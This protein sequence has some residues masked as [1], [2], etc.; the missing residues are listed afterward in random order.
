MIFDHPAQIDLI[1]RVR[2]LWLG[3]LNDFP[4]QGTEHWDGGSEGESEGDDEATVVESE[5]R[6][7]LASFQHVL[8]WSQLAPESA[9]R[10]RRDSDS[11]RSTVWK[12]PARNSHPALRVNG[13]KVLYFCRSTMTTTAGSLRT[14]SSRHRIHGSGSAQIASGPS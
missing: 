12:D 5:V 9:S 7:A 8:V 6:K 2:C 10:R 4:S 14:N 11:L 13:R 3:G 1:S